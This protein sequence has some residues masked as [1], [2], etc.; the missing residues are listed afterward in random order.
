M[1]QQSQ[2]L[3]ALLP[4]DTGAEGGQKTAL[5]EIDASCRVPVLFFFISGLAWLLA[6]TVLALVASIKLHTP[7]FLAGWEWLTFSNVR[8]AHLNTVIYGFASQISV[9]VSVWLMCR[10][11]RIPLPAP[12]LVTVA[13]LFYNLGVTVGV[14]GILIGDSTAIEW[15]EMPRYATPI[16]FFSY[17]LIAVWTIITFRLRAERHLYVSQWYLLAAVLWFPWLYGTAQVMLLIEPV[18]GVVQAA[19]NWWFAHNVL[20][21][22]FTPIGLASI[23]Y[24]IPK[25]IGRPIHSYYLSVLGFWSLVL[26][27]NYH[28][29]QR[30]SREWRA[31]SAAS[32]RSPTSP[33]IPSP[34]RTWACMPSSRW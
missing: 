8:T 6:G 18:R 5:A 21:L 23:Y 25:V 33:T 30:A 20:G 24:F 4:G 3:R 12:G 1:I 31:P 29:K 34:M 2:T 32:A 13:N 9:G 16:L 22:W 14:A 11:C 27:Y 19:V 10:L 28:R 15:L 17:A 26:F 7:G